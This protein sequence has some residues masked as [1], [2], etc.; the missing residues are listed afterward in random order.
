MSQP[1]GDNDISTDQTLRETRRV[2]NGVYR[3][4][5][6]GRAIGE[7]LWGIFALRNG[8]FRLMTEID[9][10]WPI[11]NQQ[12]A[13]LDVD[14]SWSAQ[15]M[16]AQIDIHNTRRMVTCIVADDVLSI[17]ITTL[18]L[19]DED[20]KA[21]NPRPRLLGDLKG[22]VGDEH[23]AGKVVFQRAMSFDPQ[24]HLDFD[25]ALFNF[26]ALQ[27]LQLARGAQ[28][29]F[30]SVAPALPSL[31][32]LTL[33]QTYRYERDE[34]TGPDANRMIAR[35]YAIM[36]SGADGVLTTFWADEHGIALRQEFTM[37]GALHTC[38]M[39]NYRW[40]G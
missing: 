13:N 12:R 25:S 10:T 33:R 19:R 40:L 27:R 15:G 6:N 3:L 11:P 22:Q 28:S 30:F 17:E 7:E 8:W 2:A 31:E 35:R 21:S 5:R 29:T 38:E 37:N 1:Y 24:S 20:K 39:T 32:P 34:T 9:L 26:V 36:E 18:R 16:W 23:P 14:A 4:S